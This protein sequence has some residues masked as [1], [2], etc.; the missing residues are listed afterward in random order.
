MVS[1]CFPLLDEVGW[2]GDLGLLCRSC[3]TARSWLRVGLLQGDLCKLAW[4]RVG[5]EA[6]GCGSVRDVCPKDPHWVLSLSLGSVGTV[7]P[8]HKAPQ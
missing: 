4:L 5:V 7:P 6:F 8:F 3:R 1:V 2:V